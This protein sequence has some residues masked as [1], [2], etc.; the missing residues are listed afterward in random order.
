MKTIIIIF[1]IALTIE[2][3]SQVIEE[4]TYV[5]QV[6][7]REYNGS[8][9]ARDFILAMA[10]DDA[11]NIYV[12]GCT[13]ETGRREDFTTIKYNSAGVRLWIAQYDNNNIFDWP[14]AMAVDDEGNVYVTGYT[15]SSSTDFD[16]CTIKYN[17]SGTEMWVKT[18][19]GSA[20]D[21]DV[22]KYIALDEDGN[23]YVTGYSRNSSGD[24]DI[25]T[26]KYTSY[27]N[28]VW[29]RRYN[30]PGNID[31]I[32]SQIAIDPEGNIYICGFIIKDPYVDDDGVLIKYNS[33]G[34]YQWA[35][36]YS[37]PGNGDDY[38][39]EMVLGNN[40]SIYITG[41][42][43]GYGTGADILTAKYSTA[44]T[45][46]WIKRYNGP[47]N[48]YDDGRSLVID[49][50]G[51][52]YV[53]GNSTSYV[54]GLDWTT[55]KYN[56]AGTQQWL[57]RFNG[58][59]NGDD[60][61]RSIALDASNNVYVTGRVTLAPLDYGMTTIKYN[62]SGNQK[63]IKEYNN[64]TGKTSEGF[65]IAVDGSKNVYVAGSIDISGSGHGNEANYKLIKYSQSPYVIQN[66]SETPTSF[67]L[68]QNY[69]N[70][71]NPVTNIKFDIPN[72][73]NV[74]LT[75]FDITGREIAELVNQQLETGTYNVDFDASHLATGTYFYRIEA[76]DFKEVKKMLMVK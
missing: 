66:R 50:D 41:R 45:V 34:T 69:P 8:D 19:N 64:A 63:W 29:I 22:A 11:G 73:S 39:V 6:W 60:Y 16:Y 48:G 65:F 68:S 44:G 23:V 14:Y 61:A 1:L 70:P 52:A 20:N 55:I 38:F 35:R 28:A 58:E 13:M 62:S 71:F 15:Y 10:V 2:C 53:S 72:A 43:E 76:G 47:G 32:P 37:G 56:S 26:I 75:V 59:N 40:N 12:T 5:Q 25:T 74:K 67:S 3:H 21:K 51:N 18:Y 54:S 31:E 46:Q 30:D 9:D 33:A 36:T 49:D 7:S 27:G 24:H 42:S 57:K 4:G 17:S